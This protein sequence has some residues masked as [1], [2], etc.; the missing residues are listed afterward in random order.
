MGLT[1]EPGNQVA[2]ALSLH[3][4]YGEVNEASGFPGHG[5]CFCLLVRT[6]HRWRRNKGVVLFFLRCLNPKP[7]LLV[8]CFLWKWGTE[9]A[10][11]EMYTSSPQRLPCLPSSCQALKSSLQRGQVA[12][13]Q[14]WPSGRLCGSVGWQSAIVQGSYNRRERWVTL[15]DPH[16]HQPSPQWFCLKPLK[17]TVSSQELGSRLRQTCICARVP[18]RGNRPGPTMLD[19][20]WAATMSPFAQRRIEQELSGAGGVS[21]VATPPSHHPPPPHPPW[22]PAKTCLC[23]RPFDFHTFQF[24][25]HNPEKFLTLFLLPIGIINCLQSASSPPAHLTLLTLMGC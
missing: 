10:Q 4:G 16:T 18:C 11:R 24:S 7:L 15:S 12:C 8:L 20:S 6:E 5:G 23:F 25:L 17:A 22:V 13:A 2:Q 1:G 14:R 19:L 21:S 9:G 3:M